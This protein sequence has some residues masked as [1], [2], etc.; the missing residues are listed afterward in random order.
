MVGYPNVP[1]REAVYDK[2]GI[3]G[4]AEM[5]TYTNPTRDRG[6]D[7][8]MQSRSNLSILI[9]SLD[10]DQRSHAWSLLYTSRVWVTPSFQRKRTW[11][12]PPWYKEAIPLRGRRVASNFVIHIGLTMC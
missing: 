11:C 12:K 2:D 7:S 5:V 6:P 1:G 10:L 8:I 4:D 3:C 9:Q